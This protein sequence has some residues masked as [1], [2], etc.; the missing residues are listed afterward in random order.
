MP[1]PISVV[2][3]NVG[4]R[5]GNWQVRQTPIAV[6]LER[7]G[8]DIICLQEVWAEQRDGGDDQAAMLAD[9][10]HMHHVRHETA[11]NH[12]VSFSNAVLSRWPII[13]STNIV[14]PNSTGQPGHRRAV[15]A[16]ISTPRGTMHVVTTHLD[17]RF[18][19][20]ATRTAQLDTICAYIAAL[21][22]NPATDFPVIFAGDLN[23]VPDSDE[24]RTLTGRRPPHVAGQI[25][26]DAWEA[27]GDGSPGYTWRRDNPLLHLAQ[28]PNRRLDYLFTSWPRTTGQGTS[29]ACR[30][31]GVDPID[32]V[33][34]S[35][36][37]GVQ[38]ILR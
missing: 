23:A 33:M 13:E 38:A 1:A 11:S 14:L 6:T 36:H 30:L 15:H 26:S 37:A 21:Q 24:I 18:D 29:I 34:A 9:Q 32:G 28:W 7:T 12:E 17:H 22:R 16:A 2:T 25:F 8:A 4:W 19:G 35:D 3:W 5:F 31:I 10:L 27:S 20:S